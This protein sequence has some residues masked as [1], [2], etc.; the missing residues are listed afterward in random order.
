MSAGARFGLEAGVLIVGLM[1]FFFIGLMWALW[2]RSK[3]TEETKS[4]IKGIF[5]SEGA[6]EPE[7]QILAIGAN[8]AEVQAP[9]SHRVG[10]YFL[11]R[12]AMSN[13]A[14]PEKPFM[15]LWFIQV[16]ILTQWWDRDNPEPLT[17]YKHAPVATAENIFS[18]NDTN[19]MFALRQAKNELEAGRRELLK[20]QANKLSA[21]AVYLLLGVNSIGIIGVFFFLMKYGSTLAKIAGSLGVK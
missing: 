8:G 5:F 10:T 16:P 1:F 19:Y 2:K 9:H 20:A 11:N 14:Y 7:V 4:H 21:N 18:S 3:Y 13:T 12:K 15:G 6:S 17:S